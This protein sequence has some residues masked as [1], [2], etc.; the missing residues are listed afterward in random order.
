MSRPP[1][2]TEM[3]L[4][5]EHLGSVGTGF[6]VRGVADFDRDGRAYILFRESDGMLSLHIINGFQNIGAQLLGAVGPNFHLP[7]VSDFSGDIRADIFFR[8]RLLSLCLLNGLQLIRCKLLGYLGCDFTLLALGDRNGRATA[9]AW[10]S[11]AAGGLLSGLQR[12][13]RRVAGPLG[14]IGVLLWSISFSVRVAAK[15]YLA[16]ISTLRLRVSRVP[17]AVPSRRAA[18]VDS[19]GSAEYATLMTAGGIGVVRANACSPKTTLRNETFRPLFR[20]DGAH[21]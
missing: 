16:P 9:W 18:P 10:C 15:Q 12:P 11:V 4:Q 1:A 7:G 2:N 14:S 8:R 3:I 20:E 19:A 17:V 5:G 6:H 13:A 21:P